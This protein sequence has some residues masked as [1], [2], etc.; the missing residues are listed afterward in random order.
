MYN[1]KKNTWVPNVVYKK[2]FVWVR[3]TGFDF[4]SAKDRQLNICPKLQTANQNLK[5]QFFGKI[6]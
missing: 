4:E 2:M 3:N 5:G 6:F 1:K